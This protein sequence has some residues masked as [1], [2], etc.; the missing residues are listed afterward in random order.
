MQVHHEYV[1]MAV[2]NGIDIVIEC[3]I[4]LK[5]SSNE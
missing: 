3:V 5:N 4:M 1:T 2:D